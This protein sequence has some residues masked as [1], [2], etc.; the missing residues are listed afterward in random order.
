M[1]HVLDW[2]KHGKT[3]EE[4]GRRHSNIVMTV[5]SGSICYSDIN[6]AMPFALHQ[7]VLH[8]IPWYSSLRLASGWW[9]LC[10]ILMHWLYYFRQAMQGYREAGIQGFG[11]VPPPSQ[12][13]DIPTY[14]MK[15]MTTNGAALAEEFSAKSL[16]YPCVL[17]QCGSA[18][19][20]VIVRK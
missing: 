16:T 6:T 17:V 18:T 7:L 15:L 13:I 3:T 1:L 14:V 2:S 11:D 5:Q 20:S 4:S 19:G 9:H 10:S 12:G 8:A